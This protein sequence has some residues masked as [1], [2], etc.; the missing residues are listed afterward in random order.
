M[1]RDAFDHLRVPVLL[2]DEQ[3]LRD[4]NPAAAELLAAPDRGALL[5]CRLSDL[6]PAHPGDGQAS[7]LML[8]RRL[9]EAREQGRIHFEGAFRRWDGG[10]TVAEACLT[11]LDGADGARFLMELRPVA[12]E[13]EGH[14][15]SAAAGRGQVI[16]YTSE[17]APACM[18]GTHVEIEQLKAT[19]AAL[20]QREEELREAQEI[21]ELGHWVSDFRRNEIR[22]SEKIYEIFGLSQEAWGATHGAF[23]QAVHPADRARVQAALEAA[24]STGRYM[25]EHRIRRPD[26]HVRTVQ[27]RGHVEFD[28]AGAPVRM[29][30]TVQDVT[31]QR[32]LEQALAERE[33]HYR[34]LVEQHPLMVGRFRPDTT[35]TFVNQTLAA[36]YGIAAETLQGQRWLPL[37]PAEEREAAAEHLRTF[38][39]EAPV[40]SLEHR[41]R[42]A[43]GEPR[44]TYWTNRAFFDEHGNVTHFQSVGMD[45]TERKRAEQARRQLTEL[46]EHTPDFIAIASPEGAIQYLNQA[47]RALLGGDGATP[48]TWPLAPRYPGAERSGM[49][50]YH[51]GWAHQ[52]LQ[53]VGIPAALE[54]G[55]WEGESALLDAAGEEIPMSQV[56]VAHRDE[57]GEL[58]RL[59]TIMRDLRRQKRLQEALDQ[60]QQWLERLQAIT[61]DPAQSLAAKL[62][63][64]LAL[65]TEVFRLPCAT[66]GHVEEEAYVL[67]AVA[68]EHGSLQPGQRQELELSCSSQVLGAHGPVG[69]H[70]ASR[71]AH[72][73][74]PCY[75]VHAIEA[76]LGVPVWLGEA[77]YGT[78]LFYSHEPREPYNRF[79]RQFLQLMGQWVTY[80]LTREANRSALAREAT[81]DHLTGLYNRHHLDAELNRML[82]HEHRYGRG[83]GFLLLDIDHFK[84]LN[85]A[86]GHD[87]G[88]RVLIELAQRIGGL[89]READLFARW[90]GEEFAV[91]VP[92]AD[93]DGVE[94]LA[95]RLREH[96]VATPFA[97]A[98]L[99]SISV[100]ATLLDPHDDKVSALQRV[101]RALYQAKRE[102]RNRV[103][104]Q[105]PREGA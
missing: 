24:Y 41:V 95:E 71:A 8:E 90:G 51:P 75:W 16:R 43:A 2:L 18:M 68:P 64:L 99:V 104:Y 40:G 45:V 86:Y 12:V 70:D 54:Q 63:A 84:A 96:V 105:S 20:R 11:H 93:R 10:T 57:D 50:S 58:V 46:I 36:F 44:W 55:Y 92:E 15:E 98:G 6:A 77:T 33:A 29:I 67:R 78:L 7:A 79:E 32:A 66:L 5:R 48:Q 9:G 3:Q 53:E 103:V 69:V 47:G 61:G 28:G 82:A 73:D 85:D 52:R 37:L 35:M 14:S 81:T 102:G 56:L 25:V 59:S 89:L 42:N 27:E 31:S 60:R 91:L 100:G 26:G 80:E 22:W 38:T 17:G 94:R 97:E 76:Y 65:G 30:G 34:A 87:A 83:T 74:H 88:D 72:R 21:A 39:P 1:Y 19:E 62:T 4:A 49:P 23:M 101:D 13:A